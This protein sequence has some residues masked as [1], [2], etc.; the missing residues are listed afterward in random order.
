MLYTVWYYL[1]FHVTAV[2]LGTYYPRI[3][4]HYRTTLKQ[5]VA[6]CT[7]SL[8]SLPDGHQHFAEICCL[9]LHGWIV[10]NKIRQRLWSIIST[11]A[12]WQM[13]PSPDQYI[14][15]TENLNTERQNGPYQRP[16]SAA[17]GGNMDN[18]SQGHKRCEAGNAFL[19]PCVCN[20]NASSPNSSQPWQWKQHVP[21]Q[22]WYPPKGLHVVTTQNTQV[23][24]TASY[25]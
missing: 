24:R 6:F 3:W 19:A 2:G 18:P 13:E 15:W 23:F 22:L 5:V 9:W 17:T 21:S 7:V 8:C 25:I 10:D 1:R 16:H 4:R 11:V 14:Q 12:G 20:L